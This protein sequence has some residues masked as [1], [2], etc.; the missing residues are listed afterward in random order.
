[1][2]ASV[3]PIVLVSVPAAQAEPRLGLGLML[4][5]CALCFGI[6]LLVWPPR[7]RKH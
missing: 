6:L 4:G 1:V 5:L 7:R 3:M 2:T